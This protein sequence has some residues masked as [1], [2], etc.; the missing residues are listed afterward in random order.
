[1]NEMKVLLGG[2]DR[3][4]ETPGNRNN[5]KLNDKLETEINTNNFIQSIENNLGLLQKEGLLFFPCNGIIAF[6]PNCTTV[7]S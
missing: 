6:N 1:M 4:Q 7:P 2:K 5:K 3:M